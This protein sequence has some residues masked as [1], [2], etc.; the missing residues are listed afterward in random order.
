MTTQLAIRLPEG[1]V[2]EIDRLVANG[3]FANRTEAVRIAIERLITEKQRRAVD[4]AIT[5]GYSAVPDLPADAW[6]AQATRAMVAAE[7]W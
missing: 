6:I 5:A 2:A 3:A 4:D 1:T 7:P